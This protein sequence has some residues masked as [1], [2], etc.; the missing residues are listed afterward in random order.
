MSKKT[1]E[2]TELFIEQMG[3]VAQADGLPRIAG[4]LM[5]LMVIEGGPFSFGQLS[6]RLQVSRG[7]ISTNTRLL[8]NLGVIER[9]A[10]AGERQDYFQLAPS[11]YAQLLKGV[12]QRMSKAHK[13]V[14]TTQ[15]TL[16]KEMKSAKSRLED[17]GEFYRIAIENTQSIIKKF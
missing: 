12:V 11:P 16:P 9:V 6:D 8:E 14:T 7:S 17:L 1:T 10:H 13:L 3:L 15:K 2:A 5:G 4:R